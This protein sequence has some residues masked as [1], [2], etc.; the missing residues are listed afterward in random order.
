M[1]NEN[2]GSTSIH[3]WNIERIM[4]NQE[5]GCVFV[6]CFMLKK[7]NNQLSQCKRLEFRHK[8]INSFS[9]KDLCRTKPYED[10]FTGCLPHTL[11]LQIE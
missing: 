3:E 5:K 1:N 8:G 7:N 2:H 10:G 11:F 9:F 4:G 6:W